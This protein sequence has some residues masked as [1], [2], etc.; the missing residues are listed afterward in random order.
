[1]IGEN[2]NVNGYPYKY[3]T[4]FKNDTYNCFLKEEDTDQELISSFVK[5]I[6]S[7][8]NILQIIMMQ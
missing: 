4:I 5:V 8:K 1:M 6:L 7:K 3:V 2:I